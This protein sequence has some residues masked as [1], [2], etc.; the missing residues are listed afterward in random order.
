MHCSYFIRR[1]REP[2][3]EPREAQRV[4]RHTLGAAHLLAAPGGCL[5]ASG[6]PSRRLFAYKKPLTL[7]VTRRNFSVEE[8]LRSG[9]HRK[10]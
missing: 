10:P 8:K 7:K 1:H 5:V 9:R 3:G 6:T 4:P 2:E